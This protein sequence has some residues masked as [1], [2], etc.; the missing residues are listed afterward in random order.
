MFEKVKDFFIQ[1][2]EDFKVWGKNL[3]KRI[4]RKI[5]WIP[6]YNLLSY[7][8]GKLSDLLDKIEKKIV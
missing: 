2:W 1:K 3:V 7:K 4:I 6:V 5:F 8:A